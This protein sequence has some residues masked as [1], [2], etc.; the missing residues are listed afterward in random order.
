MDERLAPGWKAVEQERRAFPTFRG[1][2]LQSLQRCLPLRGIAALIQY[3]YGANL[4]DVQRRC[5]N[6][7]PLNQLA[8][9]LHF[10]VELRISQ[11]PL[12]AHGGSTPRMSR[13]VI[14]FLGQIS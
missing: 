3:N 4:V 2:M 1:S 14:G 10:R 7:V 6:N 8:S 13:R 11:R 12:Q 5:K 9:V